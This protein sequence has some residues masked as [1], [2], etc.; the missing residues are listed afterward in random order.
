MSVAVQQQLLPRA[1]VEVAYHR[2][3]FQDFNVTDNLALGSSDFDKYSIT[4]P[5]DPRLPGGGGYVIPDLY[6]V[7]PSKFGQ[8]NNL[9]TLA[10]KY[11]AWT[12]HFN[13]VDVT[14]SVRTRGGFTFQGGT[15]T[16]QSIADTCA[17]RAVLPELTALTPTGIGPGNL[18][19]GVSP[20]DPRC[21]YETGVLTQFRALSAYVVPKIDVQV[22]GTYQNK[23]GAQIAANYAVPSAVVAQ[24]LGRPLSGNVPNVTVNLIEPGTL[25]GERITQLDLRIA[26]ILRFG[27]TQTT[28]GADVYNAMNV[29]TV[30][31]YNPVFV[32]GGNWQQ[33]R[34][35]MSGRLIRI[36][37]EMSF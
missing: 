29:N 22:S 3:W 9:L 34:N 5:S 16:G 26:K 14:L 19:S 8:I 27:G 15:S 37:A 21:R 20:V 31:V 32:P 35:V 33:P 6:D 13:G 24:S 30:L 28:V 2:R 12:E 1:S 4:A 25:Y 18:M 17:V 10:N 11:G 36:S 23:P 7:V